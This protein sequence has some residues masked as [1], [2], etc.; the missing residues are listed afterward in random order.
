MFLSEANK[1][2]VD[3]QYVVDATELG[4]R[5]GKNWAIRGVTLRIKLGQIVG[6]IGPDGAGKSTLL[7]MMAGIL[8]PSEGNCHV[9][10]FDS[11]RQAAQIAPHIGYMAQGFTLYERLTVNENLDFAAGIRDVDREDSAEER[12]RLLE[13]AGLTPFLE[14]REGNL[15]GGMRKKLALCTNLIHRPPLLI[16]DEPGLGVDPLS[17]RDLWEMLEGYRQGGTTIV[18]STSYMDEAERCD[19]IVILDKGKAIAEG[20]PDELRGRAQ[21]AVYRVLSDDPA[22][23]EQLLHERPD[24]TS[25]Q[26]R[27]HEVR[28]TTS[29]VTRLPDD[30]KDELARMGNVEPVEPSMEDIFAI[31]RIEAGSTSATPAQVQSIDVS[32]GTKFSSNIVIST[33]ALTRRFDSFTAVDSVSMSI[34]AGEIVCLAGPNGAGKTTL[35]RML[36]GLL[37]PSEGTAVV[38][39]FD[40]SKE[41]RKLREHIGYMSQHFSLYPDLTMSE[42]LSFFASAYGLRGGNARK[43]IEWASRVTGLYDS[44]NSI[45][46]ELSGALRQRLALACS[47]LHRPEVLFLDEPT[48]GIDPIARFR[49]WRLIGLL[50]EAGTSVLVS[51]HNLEEANYCDRLGLMHEGRLIALDD[52]DALKVAIGIDSTDSVESTFIAYIERERARLPADV[53]KA[54]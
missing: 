18:L 3:V 16:L 25:V 12:T 43:A 36:C 13:M 28:F 20:T 17:R 4:R 45:V 7:Q 1:V 48:S 42:N 15:S 39:G 30:L 44:K 49:F 33:D 40:V 41:S 23:A 8:D 53:E 21:G 9:L 52:L 47:I 51:T 54:A 2:P 26:W 5:Y 11:V 50:T 29:Q 32:Q 10:G 31:S 35:I 14:R 22:S 46:S 37:S 34:E 19:Q 6:L 27:P 24:V 38:S